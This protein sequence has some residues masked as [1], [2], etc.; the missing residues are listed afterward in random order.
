MNLCF[1]FLIALG[2][3]ILVFLHQVRPV[4]VEALM[5]SSEKLRKDVEVIQDCRKD[6]VMSFFKKRNEGK[7][8]KNCRPVIISLISGHEHLEDKKMMN[9]QQQVTLNHPEAL[10]VLSADVQ[11]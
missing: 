11:C 5:I 10:A 7:K 2:D 4:T 1:L 6:L 8:P 3:P 9:M